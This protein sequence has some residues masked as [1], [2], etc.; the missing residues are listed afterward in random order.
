MTYRPL[1]LIRPHPDP[2]HLTN[3]LID[4]LLGVKV[5]ARLGGYDL[6]FNQSRL[7]YQHC[8]SCAALQTSLLPRHR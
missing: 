6:D 4:R 5:Q 1:I 8:L 2:S 7:W 3:S